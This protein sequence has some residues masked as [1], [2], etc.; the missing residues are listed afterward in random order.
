MLYSMQYAPWVF[1]K[2]PYVHHFAERGLPHL[3]DL[4]DPESRVVFIARRPMD[5]DVLTYQLRDVLG[6]TPAQERS[7]R[8]RLIVSC[9]EEQGDG[10]LAELALA[11]GDLVRRLRRLVGGAGRARLSVFTAEAAADELGRL[12]GVTPSERSAPLADRLG[13]KAGGKAIF[14]RA[15]VPSPRGGRQV[16]H[17]VAELTAVARRMARNGPRQLMLK[18]DSPYW[19][20]G[21]GNMTVDAARLTSTGSIER[22][23]VEYTQPWEVFAAHVPVAGV[24]VEEHVPDV[25]RS[26]SSMASVEEDGTVRVGPRYVQFLAAGYQYAGASFG[27]AGQPGPALKDVTAIGSVLAA[28]GYRG[29]FG[30]DFVERA[31]GTFQAIEINLRKVASWHPVKHVEA[32]TGG[33]IDAVGDLRVDGERVAYVFRQALLPSHSALP[34][35]SDVIG[36][37]RDKGLLYD[38]TTRRGALLHL[39]G[40]LSP[41]GYVEVTCVGDNLVDA[42]HRVDHV[43]AELH[44]TTTAPLYG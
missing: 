27:G 9:P 8:E 6:M 32:A 10:T 3:A 20:S 34:S 24:I 1:E 12:I 38:R 26:L 35:P 36:A 42:G 21:L 28:E 29:V 44:R 40:A 17:S 31:D 7:A 15:G 22:S 18:L 11:D 13:S 23:V 4:R 43:L 2:L 39:L 41:C 30:L 37:L 25:V 5:P 14:D 19:G 33:H 16:L